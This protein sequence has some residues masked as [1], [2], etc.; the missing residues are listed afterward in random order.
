VIIPTRT[1][2][3]ARFCL[4]I[5]LALLFADAGMAAPI[6]QR[7][8]R[9]LGAGAAT[10]GGPRAGAGPPIKEMI[11]GLYVSR[12]QQQLDLA[13]EQFVRILPLLRQSLQERD[14]LGQRHNRTLIALRLA[15]GED[16]SEAELERL[17]ELV[18][19][20]DVA[21]RSIQENLLRS[22]DPELSTHQRARFRIAQSNLE[23]RIRTLIER[24]RNP[25]APALDR[26]QPQR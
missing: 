9:N 22:V 14:E 2:T 6:M 7:G 21:L 3:S 17:M 19:E 12:M 15:L 5:A 11:E 16:A 10:P 13:D 20:S 23:N 8:P 26:R 1:M 25:A 4:P 24:S 18:D